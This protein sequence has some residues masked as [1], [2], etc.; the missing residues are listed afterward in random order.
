M[1]IADRDEAEGYRYEVGDRA[2]FFEMVGVG[3]KGG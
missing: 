3:T 1:E 2:Y